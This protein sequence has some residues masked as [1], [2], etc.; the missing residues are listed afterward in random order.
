MIGL[1]KSKNW[2]NA[3][4]V[5]IILF[6]II[7]L[8]KE[9]G[10]VGRT[11]KNRKGCTCHDEVASKNVLV[12]IA[13]PDTMRVGETVTF[14]VT[15]SGATMK[16]AGIN[17]A[18]SDGDLN[19]LSRDLKKAKGELTH[20]SPKQTVSGKSTFQF[21]YSAPDKAGEQTIFASGNLADMNGKK[22]GD[23]WNHAPNKRVLIINQKK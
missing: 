10:V 1:S 19:P 7:T 12:S 6:A 21:S 8:A 20:T 5:L 9:E 3:A 4:L 13:G 23:L 14:S 18:A 2:V 11:L 17:I 15:I 16:A 22:T